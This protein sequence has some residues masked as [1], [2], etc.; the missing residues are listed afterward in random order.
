VNLEEMVTFVRS[1]VDADEDDAPL[2]TLTIYATEAYNDV[3]RRRLQWPHLYVEY[4]L[5]VVAGTSQYARADLSV[6]DLEF[7]SGAYRED[8]RELPIVS[9]DQGLFLYSDSPSG[10]LDA[11]SFGPAAIHLYPTP[12]SD[13]T[14]KVVGYRRFATWPTGSEGPDLPDEFHIAIPWAMCRDFWLGQEELES[15]GVYAQRYEQTV[16]QMI[17]QAARSYGSTAGP[18]YFTGPR[19]RGG[20]G[21][22]RDFVKRQVEG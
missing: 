6:S 19:R 5:S 11:A 17:G 13:E 18:S 21:S 2:S 16:R 1:Q 12:V 15:A 7:V 20:R 9:R 3:K 8:G 14:L 4:D 10:D 22:Y